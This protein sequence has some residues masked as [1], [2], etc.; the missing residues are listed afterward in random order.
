MY[1]TKRMASLL[2]AGVLCGAF[3]QSGAPYILTAFPLTTMP[4]TSKIWV[5]WSGAAR[6]GSLIAPDSGILYYDRSPGGGKLANYRYSIIPD[7]SGANTFIAGVPPQR[8]I[9]F[10]PNQQPNM[11][12]GVFYYMVGWPMAADTFYSNELQMII[13]CP[14]APQPKAPTG[15]ISSLT[16]TF[17]WDPNPGVPY[18]HVILSDQEIKLD[19]SADGA[20]SISGLS[21]IWQAIT[22]NT[23]IIYG[24]PDPSGT[25]TASPPP[26][27]PGQTYSWVVLNNYGNA[28][29]YTSTKFGLPKSFSVIGD[30]LKPPRN[31]FPTPSGAAVGHSL[32][33]VT[34]PNIT[35]K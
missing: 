18:Y 13:E 34:D 4:A 19:S 5:Q 15:S 3:S 17:Q 8:G 14:Q 12:Y 16:P 11:G 25:I 35:F 33:A 24:A 27:S 7:I 10:Y 1:W 30:T 2:V 20:T 21:V 29:A 32:N 9:A 6:P 28:P 23:Q 22:P 26:L 31:I